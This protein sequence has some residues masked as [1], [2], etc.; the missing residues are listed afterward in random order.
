MTVKD[1]KYSKEEQ[2]IIDYIE[3]W[4]AKSIPNVKEE[5]KR[6][7][8]I[9]KQYNFWDSEEK[10]T[11]NIRKHDMNKLIEQSKKEWISYQ[12]LISGIIHKYVNSF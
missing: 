11:L 1:I 4:K 5:I 8:K 2:Q 10:I 6:Y 3:S 12:K 9:A 7:Q